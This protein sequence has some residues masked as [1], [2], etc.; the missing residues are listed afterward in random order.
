M[1]NGKYIGGSD[2]TGGYCGNLPS[3]Q[4][5]LKQASSLDNI[6]LLPGGKGFRTRLGNS[7]LNDT[8][9][10]S[11]A[12]VQGMGQLLTAAGVSDIVVVCGDKIYNSDAYDGT[13][14][15]VT[16]AVTVAAGAD[17]QWNIFTFN[18][19][20]L[21][22]G[23]A[24]TGPNAPFKYTGTGDAAA[25]GGTSPSAHGALAANNRVFAYRASAAPSTMYWSIIGNPTD[26]AGVGSGSAVIGSLSDAQ[27]VTGAI[28]I[29]TNYML[30]FKENSTYQMV[31]SSAPFP[32]Y[33]LFDVV[34]CAGKNAMVNVDG[35]VYFITSQG[36]MK[37][38][39]GETLK[40]YSNSADDLWASVIA[41]RYPYIC[42]YRHKGTDFD[43]LVWSVCTTGTTNNT[44]IIWDLENE[45]WL[46]CSTGFKMNTAHVDNNGTLFTGGYNGFIYKPETAATYADASETSPGTITGFWQS[47]WINDGEI[48]KISQIRKLTVLATPKATGDITISYG[49]DGKLNTKTST[50]S[51]VASSTE[52]YVQKN[53]MITG[54]GNTFEYKISQSSAAID[55]KIQGVTLQGKVYGQKGQDQN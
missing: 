7:K 33:S 46:K 54:R 21:G 14:H 20:A 47:G 25:L 15:D 55:M 16:G 24:S 40:D 6:M 34:G 5:E 28:V 44:A 1:Y 17:N 41:T 32:V 3:T 27:H 4:L 8:V 42:G 2:F 9:M 37:S 12:N 11:A 23:G 50:V 53:L 13:M 22:F 45:C 31:I 52:N 49:F 26:F 48:N 38:T 29:S 51:Q 39:D 43:W 35:V 19:Y 36:E 10:N 30:V 18:D